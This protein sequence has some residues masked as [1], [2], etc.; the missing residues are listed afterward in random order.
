MNISNEA[1]RKL[2]SEIQVGFLASRREREARFRGLLRIP[3]GWVHATFFG[4][5]E[6]LLRDGEQPKGEVI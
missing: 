6:K 4:A 2:G 3:E 1:P 5:Y